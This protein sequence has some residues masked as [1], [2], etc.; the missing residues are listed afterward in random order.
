MPPY[1]FSRVTRRAR[2]NDGE[3]FL[4]VAVQ[5]PGEM[6]FPFITTAENVLQRFA[7]PSWFKGKDDPPTIEVFELQPDPLEGAIH[8][9]RTGR[10]ELGRCPVCGTQLRC[11]LWGAEYAIFCYGEHE[12][13]HCTYA[14]RLLR[15]ERPHA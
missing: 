2:T 12:G 6:P 15:E 3:E 14:A 10:E 13:G 8:Y 7:H 5:R 1:D 11:T 9:L 4:F